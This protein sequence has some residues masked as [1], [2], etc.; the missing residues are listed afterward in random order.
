MKTACVILA[1]GEGKRMRTRLPKVMHEV[2]SE[3]MIY[4]PVRLAIQRGYRPVVVV[5][6]KAGEAVRSFLTDRFGD[7]VRF[8][9]QDPP[10]GTG[11]AV[12]SARKALKG[13]RGK[14]VILYGDVPLLQAQDLSALE[15]S[16]RNSAVA[17]LT[18]VLS[19]PTGYGRVIR[20]EQGRAVRIVEQTDAGASQ[21]RIREINAG[22]YLVRAP[23]VFSA[24]KDVRSRNKQ[25][26]YYLTDLVEL[27]RRKGQVVRAVVRK[28]SRELLGVN[29]RKEL[30]EAHR[31]M[32]RRLIDRL[33]EKGV[34]VVD[35]QRTYLGP[36]VRVGKDTVIFPDCIIHKRVQIGSGCRIGPGAVIQD[37]RIES[38]AEIRAYSVLEDC[39]VG[40][41]ALVGPFARLRPGTVLS[42]DARVGNFVEVK[43]TKVGKGSKANHLTYLGDTTIGAGV[44]VGAGTITCNYDGVNKY[45]TVIEDGVF[46]GSDTQLVAPVKVGKNAIIGAGTTVTKNVPE[47]SLAVSRVPQRNIKGYARRKRRK[48]S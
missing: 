36:E 24:L 32:S 37:A 4:Y 46:I 23:D 42:A 27:A 35:P 19:D 22:I 34:T 28:G 20:D 17:F 30:A 21:R 6:S 12:M 38:G 11:H 39:R 43:K 3:P 48:R 31:K 14:L 29:D 41:G 26:E 44:N 33:L 9:L 25:G 18:C 45:P 47:D 5:T 8:A 13:H 10:R 16:G 2:C 15:R 40:P 1:A 7:R